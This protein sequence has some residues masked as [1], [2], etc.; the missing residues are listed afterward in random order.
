MPGLVKIQGLVFIF[1]KNIGE[2][3][4]LQP[5]QYQV[6]IGNGKKAVF[7]VADRAGMGARRFGA[8]QKHAVVKK[9]A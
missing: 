9:E 4:R 1:T 7:T 6:G 8:D 2:M 5:S 3:I